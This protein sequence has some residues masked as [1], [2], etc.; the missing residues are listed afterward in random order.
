MSIPV[1][2]DL[3]K[4]RLQRFKMMALSLLLLMAAI[5]A[6]C[7]VF[8]DQYSWLGYLRAFA[9][10]AMVGGLADWFAVTALFHYPLG[11]KIPHT[12]LIENSKQRIGENLG[13][14][15]V[16]NFITPEIIR[17][18][19]EK[20]TIA[21]KLGEWLA[22]EKNRRPLVN[23]VMILASDMLQ[24]TEQE[25]IVRMFTQQAQ[26]LVNDINA[27]ILISDVL[28]YV[29]EH[30]KHEP[31]IDRA[32]EKIEEWIL[33][34]ESMVRDRVKAESSALVPGFVDNMI[35][36]KIT[37]GFIKLA[38]EIRNNPQ[39]P[40]RQ[41][42]DRQLMRL[43]D[44]V[45]S[46]P[47]WRAQLQDAK[48]KLLSTEAIEN[49]ARQAVAQLLQAFAID[50]Q[51]EDS[52]VKNYL[53]QTLQ[54]IAQQLQTEKETSDKIDNWIHYHAF[55]LI[56]KS[57]AW[58]GSLISQTVGNWQGAELSEK[59]EQEV[60]RDLQFIRINGTLVGGLVGL[61]IYAITQLARHF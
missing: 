26:T 9:E 46:N 16:G 27:G 47:E 59:L 11:I 28:N 50:I 56:M 48:T 6:I 10:A 18:R 43:R 1:S 55:R 37:N 40:I 14:F 8:I 5:Y 58:A 15:V 20:I 57:R 45:Q 36:K 42:I 23:E 29:L 17:P 44:D 21:E 61:L 7:S 52:A 30:K 54:K 25:Q 4:K 24:R 19:I 60:G 49:Y 31:F 39:H 53:H 33:A 12:N 2:Q 38:E 51:K 13:D 3:K 32:L 41:D 35:A 22:L 34:H